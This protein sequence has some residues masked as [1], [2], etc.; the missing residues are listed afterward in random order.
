M[1]K[2]DGHDNAV[3]GVATPWIG[4][5]RPE[6]LVYDADKMVEN[7][8]EEG[9]TPEEAQE[10]IT[11]NIEG[12]YVGEDTPIIVWRTDPDEHS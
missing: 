10:Y 1:L 5:N 6:V 9:M 12:A 3:I 4:G 11:F 2:I 7:L 8:T